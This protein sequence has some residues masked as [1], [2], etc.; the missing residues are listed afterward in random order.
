MKALKMR[1]KWIVLLFWS[2]LLILTVFTITRFIYPRF[3]MVPDSLG[4][5][6][7]WYFVLIIFI[8]SVRIFWADFKIIKNYAFHIFIV[9]FSGVII[10]W[11]LFVRGSGIWGTMLGVALFLMGFMILIILYHL[12]R[13]DRAAPIPYEN[14]LILEI[15][16]QRELNAI[17]IRDGLLIDVSTESLYQDLD[18][19]CKANFL[20]VRT[21]TEHQ[22]IRKYYKLTPKGIAKLEE[23]HNFFQPYILKVG[24]IDWC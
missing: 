18:K 4:Q 5:L 10:L 22:R 2:L 11:N 20:S 19:L 21:E 17:E 7:P 8:F 24:Y 6:V 15:I 3:G 1:P 13:L 16:N 23:A 14:F 12:Q 9:L